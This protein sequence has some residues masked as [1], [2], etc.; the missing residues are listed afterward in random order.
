MSL[1]FVA[2]ISF[3]IFSNIIPCSHRGETPLLYTVLPE[4]TAA[5]GGSM[6]G[7]DH[8]YEISGVSISYSICDS[9]C[10]NQEQSRK[11]IFSV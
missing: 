11:P 7:S 6:M 10:K 5:V 9:I 3:S 8:V 2:D 1:L 4:K